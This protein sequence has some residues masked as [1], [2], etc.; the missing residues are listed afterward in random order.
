MLGQRRLV[1]QQHIE[2]TIEAV[3]IDLG[4]RH[5]QHLGERGAAI[6]VFGQAELA[7]R[8]QEPSPGQ[9]W[10]IT[11]QAI[12]SRPWGRCAAKKVSCPNRFSSHYQPDPAE[13]GRPFHAQAPQVDLD[14][15]GDHVSRK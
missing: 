5:P 10:T 14:P 4:Q 11:A 8:L 9:T 1:R 7:G 6:E 15:L 2:R 13:C 12:S 3:V